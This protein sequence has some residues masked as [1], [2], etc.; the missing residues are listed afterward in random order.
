M[1]SFNDIKQDDELEEESDAY[2]ITEDDDN[3]CESA[4]DNNAIKISFRKNSDRE[5]IEE[6]D[7]QYESLFHQTRKCK[8]CDYEDFSTSELR[9]HLE[10]V[11]FIPKSEAEWLFKNLRKFSH[12]I[13]QCKQC[14]YSC[15]S[16]KKSETRRQML[17]HIKRWHSDE[18]GEDN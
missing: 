11:H 4:T 17:N 16:F 6:E 8:L 1:G 13:I 10:N 5:R 7:N 12:Y 18:K 2:D 15:Q 9:E 14:K 3:S